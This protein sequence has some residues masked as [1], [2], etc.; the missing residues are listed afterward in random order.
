[1]LPQDFE[2]H[3]APP[4]KWIGLKMICESK[5]KQGKFDRAKGRTVAQGHKGKL[6][7]GFEYDTVFCAAPA[8]ESTRMIQA[9]IALLGRPTT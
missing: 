3:G 6:R 7:K 2:K 8:L 4:N 9:L 1:V 5:L